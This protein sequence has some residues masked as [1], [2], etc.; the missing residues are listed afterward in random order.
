MT[1]EV[2]KRFVQCHDA[3]KES[4]KIRSSRQFALKIDYLP[5]N[6]NKVLKGERDIPMEALRV[7]I[8]KF[9]INPGFL[10][11]GEGKMFLDEEGNDQFRLLTI[12]TDQENEEKILH[13]PVPAMAGYAAESMDPQFISELPAYHLPGYD[14]QYGTFRSFDINGDS[15][16]PVLN[17]GDKV[18]CRFMEPQHWVTDIRDH[19]VYVIV[20]RSA[21]VVKRVIN[22]LSRHRHLQ[23]I[24]DNEEFKPY[25]INVNDIREVWYVKSRISNFDHARTSTGPSLE[26]QLENMQQAFQVQNEMLEKLLNKN[27]EN[28]N[29]DDN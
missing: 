22:N 8:E 7:A 23:L 3:M 10:Y 24:S 26:E 6:L 1:S 11:L 29:S 4:G 15:M 14:Y 13:V 27:K 9:R 5:Q 20:S 21:V 19:H 17:P 2:T 12:V 16:V 25:R 28:L 18:V